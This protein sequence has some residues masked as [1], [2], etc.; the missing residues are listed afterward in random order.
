MDHAVMTALFAGLTLWL[1]FRKDWF[2]AGIAVMSQC[3]FWAGAFSSEIF[4]TN[5][6]LNVLAA[7][8]FVTLAERLQDRGKTGILPMSLCVV[9]LVMASID[10][11]HLLTQFN[12]YF[13][14]Q[15][16]MHCVAL[17][18]IGGRG[19]VERAYG[20]YRGFGH[21]SGPDQIDGSMV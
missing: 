6:I 11:M 17:L 1:L 15:E 5:I 13:I 9:F 7:S 2:G 16:A 21:S 18:L 8:V 3:A 10:V 12:G 20:N 14:A 19:Y 4:S